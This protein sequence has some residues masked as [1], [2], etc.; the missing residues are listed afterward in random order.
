METGRKV[1]KRAFYK[2]NGSLFR[3]YA[4]KYPY[5]EFFP[6]F[7]EWADDIE[8]FNIASMKSATYS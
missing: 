3:D 2:E 8:L 7:T 5:K 4:K 6:L 1:T